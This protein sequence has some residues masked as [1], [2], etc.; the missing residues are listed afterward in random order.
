MQLTISEI[1]EQ[2]RIVR[3]K[4]QQVKEKWVKGEE[5]ETRNTEPSE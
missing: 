3:L 2:S 1:V 4:A 5:D